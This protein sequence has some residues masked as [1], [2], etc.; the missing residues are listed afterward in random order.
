MGGFHA[1][2][3]GLCRPAQAVLRAHHA[4]P[5]RLAVWQSDD[6]SAMLGR[7]VI[8]PEHPEVK[9]SS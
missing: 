4:D 9:E 8:A 5:R 2:R 3:V 7:R 1:H 6:E